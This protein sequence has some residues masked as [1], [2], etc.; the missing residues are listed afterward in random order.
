MTTKLTVTCVLKNADWT[1]ITFAIER[2]KPPASGPSR[3]C[4]A[5]DGDTT[6]VDPENRNVCG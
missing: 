4:K 5:S 6:I 2:R 3:P 1:A